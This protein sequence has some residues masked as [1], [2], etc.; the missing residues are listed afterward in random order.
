MAM[1]EVRVTLPAFA[2]H[3][4]AEFR[5]APRHNGQAQSKSPAISL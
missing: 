1:D 3:L 2:I 4:P 5:Y